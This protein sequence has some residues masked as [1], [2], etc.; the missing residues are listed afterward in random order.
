MVSK[1]EHPLVVIREWTIPPSDT[2]NWS[3]TR[4]SATPFLATLTARISTSTLNL[5]D[6]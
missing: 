3:R 1:F 6:L 2:K 5:Y 4:A